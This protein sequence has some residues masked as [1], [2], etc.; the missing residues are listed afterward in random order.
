MPQQEPTDLGTPIDFRADGLLY[1]INK[2]IFHPRGFALG[3]DEDSDALVVLGDGSQPWN[4]GE[5]VPEDELFAAF[6]A[7]LDT[8]RQPKLPFG[9]DEETPL[10]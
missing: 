1:M 5:D 8:A 4:F 6:E 3:I 10:D 7:V 2:V 9:T